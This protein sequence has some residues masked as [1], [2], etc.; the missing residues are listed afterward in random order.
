M[1]NTKQHDSWMHY[2]TLIDYFS[3][4]A[5]LEQSILEWMLWKER[6]KRFR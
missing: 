2:M 3:V 6:E 1:G 5:L 4:K